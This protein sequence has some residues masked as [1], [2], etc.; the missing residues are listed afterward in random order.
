MQVSVIIPVFNRQSTIDRAI[1]S[2][3]AQEFPAHELIVVDDGSTDSSA[4]IAQ[5][6][7]GVICLQQSNQGVSAARNAGIK[8]ATGEW[9]AFLDSDDEWLPEK[10]REQKSALQTQATIHANPLICHC[11][12]IWIRNGRR[13]NPMKKHKKTGGEIYSNCLPLCVISPSAVLIHKQVFD[14]VGLFDTELPACEDYDMWLRVCSLM[15]VLFVDKPL[16][17]K[18]GGHSDQLSHKYPAMDRFRIKAMEKIIRSGSLTNTQQQ[19]TLEQM[20]AK[21]RI[22]QKGAEKHNNNRQARELLQQIQDLL[23]QLL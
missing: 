6:N 18:Y 16:L 20:E 10:L 11:D 8:A 7:P 14:L 2:V 21:F 1:K 9:I 3:I 17:K 22:F 4:A 12:E 15:P 19:Q 13:V 23:P 5:Q